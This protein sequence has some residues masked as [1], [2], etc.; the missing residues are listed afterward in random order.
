MEYRNKKKVI[1]YSCKL[2]NNG[3][4][5]I[6]GGKVKSQNITNDN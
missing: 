5:N 1:N 3:A 6:K 2:I 4:K